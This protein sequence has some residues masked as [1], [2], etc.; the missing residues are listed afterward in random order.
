M[1]VAEYIVDFF[2]SKKIF[3]CFGYQGT[4]IARLVD[5]IY[6]NGKMNNHCCYNEQGA[7]FSGVGYAKCSGKVGFVYSTSGPGALN[8]VSGIAD[9]FYDSV[10]VVFI[11]GQL[12]FTEY[13]KIPTLRQQ[14][15]QETNIVDI[16]KPIT[17]YSIMIKKEE[18]IVT[19]LS[20]AYN[21]ANSGRKGPV[22]I[23][24]PMDI[25]KK[26]ID[27]DKV[28]DTINGIEET[29]YDCSKVNNIVQSLNECERPLFV[30][31]NAINLNHIEFE[32]LKDFLERKHIPFVTSLLKKDLFPTDFKNNM[33]II[34]SGY[35]S[36]SANLICDCKADLI[37][38]FGCRLCN[39][40]TGSYG[41]FGKDAKLIRID[42]DEN[43]LERKIN[44][45]EEDYKQ[46]CNVIIKK[47]V[48][49]KG[50]ISFTDWLDI[51]CKIKKRLLDFDDKSNNN[52]P[53]QYVCKISSYISENSN[54]CVDVGQNQMWVA[55]SFDVKRKQKVLFSGGHGAMGFALPA[56][57]GAYLSNKN[58]TYVI[59]GDG[60]MQMNIQ[61][62]QTI[63]RE[64]LPI[65]I[66]VFNNK[67]LGLIEQQQDDFFDGN[68]FGSTDEYGY[69]SP[70]FEKIAKAYGIESLS[71][72]SLTE[73]DENSKKI[74]EM[75]EP[76]LIEIILPSN[77]KAL[78]KTFF[79]EEPF[80]Q[81]PKLPKELLDELL[82]L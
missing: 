22:L 6:K 35:G 27:F 59:C 33:G 11:T 56:S 38:S 31:G 61:E 23:D 13:T 79:G 15:F 24:L 5:A 18:D 12:N 60:G 74:F 16:V 73:L 75:K 53:N 71:I 51:C 28:K 1:T 3:D 55:R 20:K 40:Q 9:A 8:L 29:S 58:N 63:Y 77:T 19:E 7:A 80:N 30:F 48:H 50:I 39:R 65:C 64:K 34:G 70:C 81:R 82:S 76:L 14:G 43:E 66:F 37:V 2:I 21:M 36:R 44:E 26:R 54:I 72:N 45:N 67:S 49:E 42:I 57:I 17:K 46:D 10:P 4:M 41:I 69:L 62:L 25:Q 47:L 68:H 32:L 78:P 52:L